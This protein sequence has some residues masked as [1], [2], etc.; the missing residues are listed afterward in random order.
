MRRRGGLQVVG[1]PDAL[2]PFP[3]KAIGDTHRPCARP[4]VPAIGER[5][6]GREPDLIRFLA[7]GELAASLGER[8]LGIDG[9]SG[10]RSVSETAETR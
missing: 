2:E 4:R 8:G 3:A 7:D 9:V 5:N 10:V 6:A 1:E